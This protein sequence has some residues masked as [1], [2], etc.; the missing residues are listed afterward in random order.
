M[1]ANRTFKAAV[2]ARMA[3]TG[4]RYTTARYALLQSRNNTDGAETRGLFLGYRA[5][6]GIRGD[7]GAAC[8]LLASVGVRARPDGRSISEGLFTGLCGGIGFLYAV[9]EYRG[10]PP[11]LSILGRY[12][13]M[14]DSFVAGGLGA[15]E[16][17][18]TSREFSTPATARKALDEAL[19][20]CRPA[21]CV[22]DYVGLAADE[23][24]VET[25]LAGYAPTVVAV[26]GADEDGVLVDEGGMEPRRVSHEAFARARAMYKKAKHRLISIEP[27]AGPL[28]LSPAIVAA[29]RATARRYT[30]APYKGFAGNFGLAGLEKWHRLLTDR[31]DPKGWPQLFPSGPLAYL[32]L[33]RTFDGIEHEFT[34]PAAGRPLYAD[35]LRTAAEL[36]GN[37]HYTA[38]AE[39]FIEAGARWSALTPTI[40]HC[41]DPVVEEGCRLGEPFRELLDEVECPDLDEAARVRGERESL[42]HRCTMPAERASALY[43]LLA[44][45]VASVLAAER[46]AVAL[47][48]TA[49]GDA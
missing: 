21:L 22:V 20:A 18:V 28:D 2:R 38:A 47:L 32:A 23:R 44:D 42:A 8:N 34:A 31:K 6:A 37:T 15:L 14:P 30:E 1:T 3:R 46:D 9:F 25:R 27:P 26:A 19:A 40:E 5:A 48:R 11:M 36:T 16:L 7:T 43:A 35:F 10:T 17:T 39:A 4:E 12:D 24:L 41:G 45:H 13:T 33:R 49:G 29:T